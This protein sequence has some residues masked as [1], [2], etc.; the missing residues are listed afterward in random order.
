MAALSGGIGQFDFQPFLSTSTGSFAIYLEANYNYDI[1]DKTISATMTWDPGT[2]KTRSTAFPGAYVRLEFQDVASGNYTS[3]DYW[4]YKGSL[5]L[6]AVTGGTLTASLTD[7]A[8][9]TNVC[10]QVATDQT[11]YPGPNCVG[12]TAPAVSPYDGFT[13]AMK[14]VKQVNLSF[15]SS[16]SYASGV[17]IDGGTSTF[18][19]FSFTIN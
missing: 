14:K 10:G 6:N 3:S 17:A 9:W 11:A 8:N 18:K 13:N 1:T 5:D 16:G 7:R 12:G 19:L 2:F 15:G 4:W